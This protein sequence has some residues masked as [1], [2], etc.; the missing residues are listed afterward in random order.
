MVIDFCQLKK[1]KPISL[2]LIDNLPGQYIEK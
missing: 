1:K 2:A